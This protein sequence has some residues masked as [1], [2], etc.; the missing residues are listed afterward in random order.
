MNFKY[1]PEIDGLRAIAV[2]SVVIFH[3]DFKIK[4]DN[5]EYNFLSGGYL[6]VDIFY[7][8]SGYL[9]THL[10]LDSINNKTFSFLDFYERRTRRLLP[11]LFAVIISSI[12][13]GYFLMLPPQFEDLSNS[14]LSSLFFLSNF[15]FYF[16]ENYF[17]DASA[18]KPLLHTWSLSIEEQ[19]Y[20]LFP[21]F[22]YLFYL[23]SKKFNLVLLIL[24]LISLVFSQFGSLYFKELNFY[25]IISRIWELAFGSLIAFYHVNN[26][27]EQKYYTSNT[28]LLFSMI[29][30]FVP[31]FIFNKSTLHPSIFTIFTVLGTGIIIFFKN[32]Q[33]VIKNFLSSKPLVGIGLI[34]YS[35]YLWHYP[36]LAF[37]RVKSPTLSEFDKFE[38]IILS[39]FLSI[40][41]FFL[42]EKPFRNKK[43]LKRK[44]FFIFISIFF[45]LIFI[46]SSYISK[47]EGLP[48]RYSKEIISLVDLNYDYKKIYQ[49]GTC[50]IENKI[51]IKKNFF[52]N[53]KINISQNKKNLFIWGDSLA[54]HLYPGIK[55]K[56][57]QNYNIWQRTADICKPFIYQ[58]NKKD[59]LKG[60]GLINKSILEEILKIK[61]ESV[62][63]S[64]FWNRSDFNEINKITTTLKKNNINRI[65]LVGP[66]P[67]WHD[68]LPKILVKKYRL[69]RKIPE[70]LPD[71]NH[72]DNY[73]LDDEFSTFA[74][75]NGLI[76][77]SPMKILCKK[78]YTCLTKIDNQADSIV[79]WDEN[80]FTEKASIFIF[81]KFID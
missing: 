35:L 47:S 25:N 28:L 56:Y 52:K 27:S 24:I 59:S 5:Y 66:S 39:L 40:L 16:S 18:L 9:I 14:A 73:F 67:R 37:K 61:P 20:L 79:N 63:L 72:K 58:N 42:I 54:A 71:K 15:Y 26:K 45:L 36:V 80:H 30:I 6:G 8:I 10:I 38:A 17:A 53:C 78:N 57:E 34:S 69:S 4:F 2:I 32:G 49:A 22:L 65:Y 60:C 23:K 19:F 21:P 44:N 50:H 75:K 46:I 62:F 70:Y 3:A 29:L 7:V 51:T 64:G 31:F 13:A 68:P 48:K 41:S 76:Y 43:I 81:S 11:A 74:K 12:V 77:V 1:R 33:G 55:Y